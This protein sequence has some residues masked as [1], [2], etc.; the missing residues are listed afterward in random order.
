MTMLLML[1]TVAL[2][3]PTDSE[4][5]ALAGE[6]FGKTLPE[7]AVCIAREMY[8]PGE[9]EGEPIPVGLMRGAQGCRLFGVVLKGYWVPIERAAL[10]SLNDDA[11]AR[12]HSR[13]RGELMLAWT[14]NVMTAFD[15]FDIRDDR[16]TYK[17]TANGGIVVEASIWQRTGDKHVAQHTRGKWFYANDAALETADRASGTKWKSSFTVREYKVEGVSVAAVMA[18]LQTRGRSLAKCMDQGWKENLTVSGRTRFQWTIRGGKATQIALVAED[19]DGSGLAKCYHRALIS[20]DFPAELGGRV[21]WSF[22]IIRSEVL[23]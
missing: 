3:A 17:S 7:K 19:D 9:F 16:P 21:I 13:K 20:I 5:V 12:A 4:I 10:A 6:A 14:T 22:N 18:S 8:L 15:Q 2:G 11:W 1:A 23:D